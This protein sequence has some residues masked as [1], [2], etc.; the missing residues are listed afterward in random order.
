[1]INHD[2]L[3]VAALTLLMVAALQYQSNTLTLLVGIRL[4]DIDDPTQKQF[5]DIVR[6]FVTFGLLAF[7]G[8]AFAAAYAPAKS[9]IA[10]I[11]VTT[12]FGGV[13]G[14]ILIRSCAKAYHTFDPNS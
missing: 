7:D 10:A 9:V 6:I 1:M 3:V 4:P 8:A 14:W 12:A 11:V 2:A 13:L 5:R